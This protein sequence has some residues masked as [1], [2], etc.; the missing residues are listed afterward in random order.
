MLYHRLFKLAHAPAVQQ[1]TPRNLFESRSDDF[2]EGNR[3]C[4][5]RTTVFL[6]SHPWVG[7]D[8]PL[9]HGACHCCTTALRQL[10]QPLC[11]P[12]PS[13][14]RHASHR[15]VVLAGA[16][17]GWLCALGLPRGVTHLSIDHRPTANS[18]TNTVL[19]ITELFT[20]AT[21]AL[22]VSTCG[23]GYNAH[24]CQ[25]PRDVPGTFPLQPN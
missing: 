23:P 12:Q 21:T 11:C 10:Q 3:R 24:H 16:C 17:V 14:L 13:C 1:L 20:A 6:L 15:H 22:P 9:E 18:I 25:L 7:A 4:G 19:S 8:S 2:F 5:R